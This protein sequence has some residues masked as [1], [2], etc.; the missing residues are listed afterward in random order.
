MAP[1]APQPSGGGD[2]LRAVAD[3]L[4]PP[5]HVLPP[6]IGYGPPALPAPAATQWRILSQP[7][8]NPYNGLNVEIAVNPTRGDV[9]KIAQGSD[10]R[11]ARLIR[12][13]SGNVYA[14]DA[15]KGTHGGIA[16]WLGFDSKNA[17]KAEATPADLSKM[18][19]WFRN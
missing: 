2:P 10:G 9:A 15:Y 3:Q 17:P 1:K 16:D 14:W 12:D 7:G 6:P 19:D 5:P 18:A 4:I 13:D 8:T 11:S